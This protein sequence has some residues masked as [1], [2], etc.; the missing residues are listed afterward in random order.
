MVQNFKIFEIKKE[1]FIVFFSLIFQDFSPITHTHKILCISI[2][3]FHILHF[4]SFIYLYIYIYIYISIAL[5]TIPCQIHTDKKRCHLPSIFWQHLCSS[6]IIVSS[7][8]NSYELANT[9]KG[10]LHFILNDIGNYNFDVKVGCCGLLGFVKAVI[11][12][13]CLRYVFYF[14]IKEKEKDTFYINFHSTI[15]LQSF[16]FFY[17]LFLIT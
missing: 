9:K 2:H 12:C 13:G 7:N 11:D 8:P 10:G 6:N 17:F 5:H 4:Y 16:L 14:R 15:F 1:L 3:H